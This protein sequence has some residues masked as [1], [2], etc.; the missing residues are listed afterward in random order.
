MRGR[1]GQV[2]A[3]HH[4]RDDGGDRPRPSLLRV[5]ENRW[6]LALA[7]SAGLYARGV[8]VN[9]GL[10]VTVREPEVYPIQVQGPKS[11]DVM[12][13]LFGDEILGIK[14]YW[15]LTTE[16]DGIPV[17]YQPNRLDPIKVGYEVPTRDHLARRRS[18]GPRLRRRPASLQHPA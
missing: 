9:S 11:K 14:Y 15:T 13:A 3:D 16:L 6:W 5:E 2:R 12:H 4:R 18:L 17:V 1:S 10:D 7:D 8:A